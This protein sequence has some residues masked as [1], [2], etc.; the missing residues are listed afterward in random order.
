MRFHYVLNV[1]QRVHL[2][3]DKHPRGRKYTPAELKQH[4][5][6]WLDICD[7]N[8]SVLVQKLERVDSGVLSAVISELE[9]NSMCADLRIPFET[10]E[11]HNAIGNGILSLLE[12]GAKNEIMSIYVSMKR[13]NESIKNY[14][15][16]EMEQR[17][18]LYLN[19]AKTKLNND[20]N[21]V[22]TGIEETIMLLQNA[23][24]E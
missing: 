9:F 8:P 19:Q 11:F 24:K 12:D 21:I 4:K 23:L 6:Q 15:I 16:M 5:E 3:N 17:P 13:V 1:M 14:G 2:Y 7:N 18:Q 10:R 22:A 20:I